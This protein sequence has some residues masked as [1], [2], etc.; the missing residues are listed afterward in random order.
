M[1]DLHSSTKFDSDELFCA[2]T[3][4]HSSGAGVAALDPGQVERTN[5]EAVY[6]FR[7]HDDDSSET[8]DALETLVAEVDAPSFTSHSATPKK[9]TNTLQFNRS[10]HAHL[11]IGIVSSIVAIALFGM[12]SYRIGI[13]FSAGYAMG[14]VITYLI[15]LHSYA[16]IC[17]GQQNDN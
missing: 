11:A 3:E 9:Q 7:D 4:E 12:A 17:S 5:A 2:D 6:D 8:V 14:T 15:S 1:S 13:V 16:C 10:L